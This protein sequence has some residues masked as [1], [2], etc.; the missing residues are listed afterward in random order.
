[1]VAR[2]EEVDG[3]ARLCSPS[4]GP[5]PRQRAKLAARLLVGAVL[6]SCPAL[7]MAGAGGAAASLTTVA[8]GSGF[9]CF[10]SVVVFSNSEDARVHRIAMTIV[11]MTETI[12][13]MTAALSIS[14]GGSGSGRGGGGGGGGGMDHGKRMRVAGRYLPEVAGFSP[15]LSRPSKG[16]ASVT[17]LHFTFNY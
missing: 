4:F 14:C 8:L 5:S 2:L 13:S 7:G 11:S 17:S 10:L 15:C 3:Q 9:A 12:V 1:M 6:S 16:F